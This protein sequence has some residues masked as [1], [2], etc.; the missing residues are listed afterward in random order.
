[1]II[2]NLNGKE[3]LKECLN[4]LERLDYPNYEIIVVD[5]GST[6]GAPELVAKQFPRVRLIREKRIGI[7]E[8]IK[9]AR[10]VFGRDKRSLLFAHE[11]CSIY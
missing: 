2:S 4:S 11:R 7:G 1:L 9:R 10:R 3:M 8:A 5:A 6:D